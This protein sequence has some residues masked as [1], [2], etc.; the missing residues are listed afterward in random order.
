VS[1]WH[2]LAPGPSA[3]RALALRL[4]H[5]FGVVNNAW[6]L[7]PN[8]E[9]LAA[10][11]MDWWRHYPAALEFAGKKFSIHKVPRTIQ[12]K[13]PVVNSGVLALECARRE[14]A[15]RIFLHGF[16]ARGSHFFGPY[17]NGLKNTPPKQRALHAG[18]FQHWGKANRRTVEVINCT[19]GSAL[20]CF[21]MASAD[22]LAHFLGQESQPERGGAP[23]VRCVSA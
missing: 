6:T 20:R 19:P 3:S 18:Q 22:D 17:A 16:D 21:P 14:G 1:D 8:A 4:P 15:T 10:V 2:L 23:G 9:F 5:P 7:A 12:V 11:D 13:M